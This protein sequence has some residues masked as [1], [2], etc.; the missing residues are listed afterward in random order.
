MNIIN[1]ILANQADQ[2]EK[3]AFFKQLGEDAKFKEE[4][5]GIQN[6]WHLSHIQN[7]Q[8]SDIDKKLLFNEFWA[9]T[10]GKKVNNYW[11][12]NFQKYAA[13]ILVALFLGMALQY[14]IPQLRQGKVETYVYQSE[15]GSV[16]TVILPDSSKVWLNSDSKLELTNR[17]GLIT[18]KLSGEAYFDI[19]HDENREFVVDVG[20]FKIKDLGTKFNV[21]AYECDNYYRAALL[22]GDIDILNTANT[23]LANINP[24]QGVIYNKHTGKLKVSNID[25]SIESAWTEGKF[26]FVKKTLAQMCEDLEK[27][28]NVDFNIQNKDLA[29]EQ[30]TCVLKKTTTVEQ[31]LKILKVTSEVNYQIL[32]NETGKDIV[33]IK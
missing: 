30:Y 33:I 14:F 3:E 7:K 12:G 23:T 17:K 16:S 18:A 20:E 10:G 27:W 1:K 6:L 15:K 8:S 24:G 2:T 5:I 29:N 25:T 4:S 22:E 11:I 31:M 32:S 19:K 28:Y 21:K 26:V 9:K 13:V